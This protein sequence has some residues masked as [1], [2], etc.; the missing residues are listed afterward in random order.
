LDD[1]PTRFLFLDRVIE[2]VKPTA[3]GQARGMIASSARPQLPTK[4]LKEKASVRSRAGRL[5]L[6]LQQTLQGNDAFKSGD[7][8]TAIGHYTAAILADRTD[9]TFPLNRAAAYLKL[10]KYVCRDCCLFLTAF[11]HEHASY[12]TQ[13]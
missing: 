10:F 6:T 2:R 12:P 13:V 5:I 1:G 9:P 4:E 3:T 11:Q 7:Y 8:P